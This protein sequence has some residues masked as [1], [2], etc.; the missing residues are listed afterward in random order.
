MTDSPPIASQ[1][2]T[3]D[4]P[5]HEPIFWWLLAIALVARIVVIVAFRENLTDDR[6]AYLTIARE[7]SQGNGFRSAAEAPLTA[8]RPP[9]YPLALAGSMKLLP[10][11]SSVATVNLLCSLLTVVL[12]WKLAREQS[13]KF[14]AVVGTVIVGLDPLLLSN[15]ALPMTET[16]FTTLLVALV[17]FAVRPELSG[18]DRLAVGL[19]F[20]LAALCRPTV[21]AFGVLAGFVWLLIQVKH[22]QHRF[23][24]IVR[25]AMPTVLASFAMLA[26]WVIRNAIVFQEFIPMTTHGGYTLLLGNNPVFYDEVVQPGWRT[27]WKGESLSRWQQSWE[28]EMATERPPIA[29]ETERDRWLSARARSNIGKS[30]NR[31]LQSCLTRF[32]RFWNPV[33]IRTPERPGSVF[34]AWGV[35]IFSSCLFLGVIAS[36]FRP[37]FTTR[38]LDGEWLTVCAWCLV[39]SMTMVHLIYWSNLRMRAPLEPFL[40]LLAIGTFHRS[41]LRGERE[42]TGHSL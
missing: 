38:K 20:G 41:S 25:K 1:S 32:L 6:D 16:M 33:P 35:G 10:E 22:R 26:P 28:R 21:W 15:V 12:V 36:C 13:T 19:L 31:F 29:S 34:I 14:A 24:F 39:V 2:T 9:L 30:P 37:R 5:S 7:L 40:A 3:E 8:Y 23:S 18:R 11:S 17:F 4:A 42:D 27:T